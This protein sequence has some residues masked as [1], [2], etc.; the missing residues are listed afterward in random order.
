MNSVTPIVSF[1]A[2]L[3]KQLRNKFEKQGASL[4]K[5][6]Y[7]VIRTLDGLETVEDTSRGLLNF[8]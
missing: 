4:G 8:Y 2:S 3:Q 1:A 5:M 6:K 7:V